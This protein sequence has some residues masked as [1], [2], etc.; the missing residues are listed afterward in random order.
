M[1]LAKTITI[2]ALFNLALSFL[3]NYLR[4]IRQHKSNNNESIRMYAK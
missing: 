3:Q 2:I 1:L 4:K